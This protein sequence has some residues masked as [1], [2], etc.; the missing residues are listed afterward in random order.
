MGLGRSNKN[1]N[2]SKFQYEKKPSIEK[3][4]SQTYVND[5]NNTNSN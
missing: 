2:I 3:G 1:A 5:T 4:L